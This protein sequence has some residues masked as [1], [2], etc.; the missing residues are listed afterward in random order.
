VYHERFFD[1]TRP[2]EANPR[3]AMT[4]G[5]AR[6]GPEDRYVRDSARNS[7][8]RSHYHY[9]HDEL[10]VADDDLEKVLD[11]V[12][13]LVGKVAAGP[14]RLD[15]LGVTRLRLER[16]KAAIPFLVDDLRERCGDPALRV[17]PNHAFRTLSHTMLSAF[18]PQLAGSRKF[19]LQPDVKAGTASRVVIGLLDSGFD[20][21][22][23]TLHG[24]C[25]GDQEPR[26]DE[27][28][29]PLPPGA[30]HGTFVASLLLNNAPSAHIK[31]R[32]VIDG[33][34]FVD[35]F[36]LAASI[37]EMAK[38]PKL[39]VLHISVGTH[40]H[41]DAGALAIETALRRLR[42]SR[43]DVVVVAP[44]GND[45]TTRPVFPAAS[46]GVIGVGA[47][48]Q[49]A[50]G[51]RHRACFSNHGWWVDACAPGVDVLGAFPD[52]DGTL[53][54][55]NELPAQLFE[56]CGGH[57]GDLD[58]EKLRQQSIYRLPSGTARWSGTSAAAPVVSGRIAARLAAG[59][60][61]AEAIYDVLGG[62]KQSIPG[63]GV[64][65]E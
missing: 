3:R 18:P 49:G 22:N 55:H 26:P 29:D 39:G 57:V 58:L 61:A 54:L 34:G 7:A 60:T 11:K 8:V 62:R 53:E 21:Q 46:K 27:R 4:M 52:Y 15:D 35:D 17:A 1:L 43:P 14:D 16:P 24:R 38:Q 37:S 19:T 13:P 36:A 59:R 65:V 41:D 45:G 63:L 28:G 23:R 32:R 44:A 47:V 50:G 40:T 42:L 31:V 6:G 48:E 33:T 64:L 2:S 56:K 51:E 10:V 20:D 5:P 9:M 30:G 25:S 12:K